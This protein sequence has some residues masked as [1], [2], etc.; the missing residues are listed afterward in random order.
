MALRPVSSVGVKGNECLMFGSLT[1]WY[2]QNLLMTMVSNGWVIPSL[3]V[4]PSWFVTVDTHDINLR[5]T[6]S[7]KMLGQPAISIATAQQ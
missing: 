7:A 4:T 3:V 5:Q 6:A 2:P 1:L